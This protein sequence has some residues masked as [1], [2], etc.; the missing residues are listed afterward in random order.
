MN[1]WLTIFYLVM[2]LAAPAAS[3]PLR[4]VLLGPPGAGKSTQGKRLASHYGIP[5]ISTGAMLRDHIKRG[6]H[7]GLQA[8]AYVE[9]GTLVPNR[10]I[11]AMLEE[12]LMAQKSGFVLD[13]FPRNVRQAEIL[14]QLLSDEGQ[15]LTRVIQLT[16]SDDE[17]V[18]RLSKRGRKD[19]Q[20]TV[21]R[22]RLRV[23]HQKT[24]PV[25]EFYR[26][27]GQL[28]TV[29]GSGTVEEIQRRIWS[30]VDPLIPWMVP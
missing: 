18:Q 9:A 25:I 29:N 24:A 21:I 22:K 1:R 23:Y 3:E 4:L 11:V 30:K 14:K 27:R 20:P 17:V 16:I 19:D 6:T 28:S 26:N 15:R 7:S 8:K 2:I 5:H 13:G 12:T 10:V